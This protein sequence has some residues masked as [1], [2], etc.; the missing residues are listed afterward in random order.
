MAAIYI[1]G[2]LRNSRIHFARP[3]QNIPRTECHIEEPLPIKR[4]QDFV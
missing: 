3:A 4:D 2:T 1:L